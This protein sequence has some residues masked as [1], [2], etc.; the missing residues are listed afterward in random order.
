MSET[1]EKVR[2][3]GVKTAVILGSGLK[4]LTDDLDDVFEISY[5]DI[6]GFPSPK[7]NGHAGKMIIGKLNHENIMF[8][9]GRIHMYEG[10]DGGEIVE[11]ITLLKQMGIEHLI[12]TNAA[13][14]LNKEINVGD[15]M[16]ITDHINFSG[17]NPL[18]SIK[19]KGND[20]FVDMVNAYDKDI[21]ENFEKIAKE[22]HITL[23]RGVYIWALGPNF[24]TPAEVRMFKALGADVAGMSTVPE[25]LIA[26]YLGMKV[27]AF[28]IITNFGAGISNTKLSHEQTLK[29]AGLGAE[30]L[31]KLL[32]KSL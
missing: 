18:I 9:S 28:S 25:T 20:I 13:G 11:F 2:K 19:D 14:S 7:I 22:N 21:N 10:G 27:S 26:R 15:V 17:K 4:S 16:M 24:E 5:K 6:N 30:S 8:L 3:I 23:K 1:L 31:K 12:L 32:K 29:M